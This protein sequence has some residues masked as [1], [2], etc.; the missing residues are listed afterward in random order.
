MKLR[1]KQQDD[2]PQYT[3]ILFLIRDVADDHL[4]E[5][6]EDE[7]KKIFPQLCGESNRKSNGNGGR[8]LE[9]GAPYQIVIK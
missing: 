8:G 1:R 6:K 5:K 7:N 9:V 4:S 2:P 3:F